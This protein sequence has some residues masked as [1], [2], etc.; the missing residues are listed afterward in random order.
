L[1]VGRIDADHAEVHGPRVDAVDALP[2]FA[3]VVGAVDAAVLP[4]V[5]ALRVL[6]VFN[7]AAELPHVRALGVLLAA[8][9]AAATA[10][11]E[12]RLGQGHVD[13][14]H[15]V[16][17]LDGKRHLVA[18]GELADLVAV[19]L[20]GLDRFL[21]ERGDHVADLQARLGRGS[22]VDDVADAVAALEVL[23]EEAGIGNSRPLGLGRRVAFADVLAV[24]DGVDDLGI[25]AV[26]VQADAAH[27]RGWQGLGHLLESLAAV[28]GPVDAGVLAEAHGGVVPVVGVLPLLAEVGVVLVAAA[29]VGGDQ[30]RVRVGRVHHHVDD[31]GLVVLVPDL[32][33]VLAA[34]GGLV[35]A[36]LLVGTVAASQGADVDNVG[37]LGVNEDLAD[38]KRLL[39]AHVLP[40]AAAVGRFVDAV[41]VGDAVARVGLAGADPDD[42][43]V[44]RGHAHVADGDGGRV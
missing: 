16:L 17:A 10:L 35:D 34:V 14:A 4:A 30:D 13:L 31:A 9:A 33:P 23:A 2:G 21:V 5:G 7:L 8:A 41:A 42:V 12:L 3:A 32:L 1:V 29:L 11:A 15:L 19:V 25:L 40:G 6:D 18:G 26:P 20:A 39:E 37:V 43:L 27:L 38:L 44:G 36:A 24:H 28:G 22:V